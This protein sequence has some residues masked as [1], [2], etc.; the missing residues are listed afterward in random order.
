MMSANTIGALGVIHFVYVWDQY[1][2]PR[3]I[4]RDD[5]RQVVQVGL[6]LFT[7]VAEGVYWGQVMA[8]AHRLHRPAERVH[9]RLRADGGQGAYGGPLKLDNAARLRWNGNPRFMEQGTLP[10]NTVVIVV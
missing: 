5:S 10:P 3:V 6:N 8:A 4:I 9:A 7:G 1:L 2:W